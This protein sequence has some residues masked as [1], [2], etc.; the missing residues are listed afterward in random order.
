MELLNQQRTLDQKFV[1][2]KKEIEQLLLD[3]QSRALG[4]SETKEMLKT[5]AQMREQPFPEFLKNADAYE[6]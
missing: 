2:R 1:D 4:D 5:R 3:A 6:N